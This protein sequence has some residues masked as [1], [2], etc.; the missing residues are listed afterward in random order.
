MDVIE[1]M[2]TFAA[3]AEVRSFTAAAEKLNISKALASKYVGQLEERLGLK[4]LHRDTRNVSLTG[5]G[6]AY[7]E[8]CNR[9]LNEFDELESDIRDRKIVANRAIRMSAPT[10][11]GGASFP[12]LISEFLRKHPDV[13]IDVSFAD[14]C[15]NLSEGGFDLALRIGKTDD[16][17]LIVRQLAS[18][19]IVACA[20]PQYLKAHGRPER[21][22]ELEDNHCI[23][24]KTIEE[25][26]CWT[27]HRE[28]EIAVVSVKGRIR[29]NCAQTVREIVLAGNG[30]GLCPEF[31]VR[32]EIRRGNLEKLFTDYTVQD[33][34][35]CAVY[36]RSRNLAPNVNV[37]IDFLAKSF[38]LTGMSDGS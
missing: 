31:F 38:K 13:A 15:A 21:P 1:G 34:T 7:L 22:S 10:L 17:Q 23:V 18:T 3:V 35:I 16:S 9:L 30:I 4:L 12:G 28:G 11:F 25:D 29:V 19:Q 5:V 36:P 14:Q 6:Q 33:Q 20:S 24:D 2:R 27:F 26:D 32:D 37:F 8:R